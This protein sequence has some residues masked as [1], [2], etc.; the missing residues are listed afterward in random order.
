MQRR[1][2]KST[3]KIKPQTETLPSEF[4]DVELV[5]LMDRTIKTKRPAKVLCRGTEIDEDWLWDIFPIWKSNWQKK[6]LKMKYN[7]RQH[8]IFLNYSKELANAYQV[9]LKYSR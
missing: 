1:K 5:R 7:K 4:T 9:F 6:G 2:H 3:K 8:C